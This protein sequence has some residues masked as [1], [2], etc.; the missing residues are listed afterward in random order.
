MPDTPQIIQPR[1]P[2]TNRHTS[3]ASVSPQSIDAHVALQQSL[4]DAERNATVSQRLPD[5]KRWTLIFIGLIVLSALQATGMQLIQM[6]M[7]DGTAAASIDFWGIVMVG[8]W[9]VS[10]AGAIVILTARSARLVKNILIGLGL[11]IGYGFIHD[12][13]QFSIISIAI[14]SFILWKIF[15]LYQSV[16][17][18]DM[19]PF[20]R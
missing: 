2:A 18:L 15:D 1:D 5:L 7:H 6:G 19:R 10:I 4:A 9:V 13:A 8:S 20:S 3:S 14:D 12:L 11:V 16:D 17:A